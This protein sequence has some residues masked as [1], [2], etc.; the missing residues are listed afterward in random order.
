MVNNRMKL[1]DR[2]FLDSQSNAFSETS[3]HVM[4]VD[5]QNH[6]IETT[7]AGWP[8]NRAICVVT[9]SSNKKG[10]SNS[11]SED[12]RSSKNCE[13]VRLFVYFID[14][15]ANG[16]NPTHGIDQHSAYR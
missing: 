7:F 5:L 3:R 16:S 1:F 15:T 11:S 4:S 10:K 2:N 8:T 13:D 9:S 12:W 14:E 6:L